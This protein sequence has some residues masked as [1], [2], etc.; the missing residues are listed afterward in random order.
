MAWARD[1]CPS[2]SPSRCSKRTSKRRNNSKSRRRS[3]SRSLSR[4]RRSWEEVGESVVNVSMTIRVARSTVE[5]LRTRFFHRVVGVPGEQQRQVPTAHQV[6]LTVETPRVPF[7]HRILFIN[8]SLSPILRFRGNGLHFDACDW[9]SRVVRL[10]APYFPSNLGPIEFHLSWLASTIWL[11]VPSLSLL[12]EFVH[13][14]V[15]GRKATLLQAWSNWIREHLSFHPKKW[16]RP[17]LVPPAPYL[18]CKPAHSPSG[19]GV[20]VQPSLDAHFQ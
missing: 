18:V 8:S 20:F 14:V 5:V 13:K 3:R 1:P 17:D 9:R 2:N 11:W 6:Q 4:S 15:Q 7:R 16:L 12:N 19:C 10:W